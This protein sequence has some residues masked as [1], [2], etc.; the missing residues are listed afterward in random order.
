MLSLGIRQKKI[1]MSDDDKIEPPPIATIPQPDLPP[2]QAEPPPVDVERDTIVRAADIV[3]NF[4]KELA[5]KR[6]EITEATLAI[7][8]RNQRIA[9]LELDLAEARNNLQTTQS[10][11]IDLQQET[12]D[13]RA[14]F[15]SFKAQLE[16]FE[17]PLPIRKRVGNGNNKKK[18]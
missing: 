14:L 1:D 11:C 8:A 12:S 3:D 7:E 4:R 16:N 2:Q 10:Q 9:Q 6:I 18:P 17:I 13:M 5:A 15:S